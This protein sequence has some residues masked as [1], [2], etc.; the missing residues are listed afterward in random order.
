MR[1]IRCFLNRTNLNLGVWYEP[2]P[3]PIFGKY[4]SISGNND[5]IKSGL[6]F[7]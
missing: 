2:V 1:L 4:V 3:T 6:D 5:M 7:L